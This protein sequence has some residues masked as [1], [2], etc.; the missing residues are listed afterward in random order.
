MD[1]LDLKYSFGLFWAW[2]GIEPRMPRPEDLRWARQAESGSDPWKS[3]LFHTVRTLIVPD[4]IH[5]RDTRWSRFLRGSTLVPRAEGISQGS[6]T[7]DYLPIGSGYCT[8]NL[9]TRHK[10]R[11][12]IRRITRVPRRTKALS[13]RYLLILLTSKVNRSF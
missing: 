4:G 7:P 8:I 13:V 6:L 12:P 10:P 9:V 3:E 11:R 1:S 2:R 5:P